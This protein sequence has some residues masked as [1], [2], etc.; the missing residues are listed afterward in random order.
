MSLRKDDPIY[1]RNKIRDLIKQ[2]LEQ[3][4]KVEGEIIEGGV[5]I[6]FEADNGDIAG[7]NLTG[8]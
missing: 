6:Y 4:L 8:K 5:R 1:Y 3:G 2:A 7:V